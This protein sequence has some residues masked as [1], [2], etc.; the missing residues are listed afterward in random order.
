M[1]E[2]GSP[3]GWTISE[4]VDC[5]LRFLMAEPAVLRSGKCGVHQEAL[6]AQMAV[7]RQVTNQTAECET[8]LREHSSGLKRV[9][10]GEPDFGLPK[11]CSVPTVLPQG[12]KM[13]LD[14]SVVGAA[15]NGED[16]REIR[17][18]ILSSILSGIIR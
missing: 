16:G 8:R 15:R 14:L 17:S 10:S 1:L 12:I 13:S 6:A 4:D 2:T 5:S 7:A 9:K 18:R 11:I 3:E